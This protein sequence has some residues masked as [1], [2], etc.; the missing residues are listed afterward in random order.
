MKT[1]NTY[2]KQRGFLAI[3]AGLALFAIYGAIGLTVKTMEPKDNETLS[4][5]EAAMIVSK[6]DD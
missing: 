5:E 6:K 1:T 3:G 4:T 2:R